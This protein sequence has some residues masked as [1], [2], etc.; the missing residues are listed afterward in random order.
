MDSGFKKLL[1]TLTDFI[2]RI[3][4]FFKGSNGAIS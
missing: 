2:M 4:D 3:I 1:Q